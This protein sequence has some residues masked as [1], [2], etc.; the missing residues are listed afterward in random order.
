MDPV[1][2]S[3]LQNLLVSNRESLFRTSVEG[4]KGLHMINLTKDSED[5]VGGAIIIYY[6]FL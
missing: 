1:D 4:N 5:F 2:I 6:S 3:A